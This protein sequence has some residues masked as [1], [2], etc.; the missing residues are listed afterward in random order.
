MKRFEFSSKLQ[1]MSVIVKQ[2]GSSV[3]ARVLVKGSPEKI[4]ELCKPSTL[5]GDFESVLDFY[6]KSGYRVLAAAIRDLPIAA[7]ERE[8]AESN[9]TFVGLLIMQNKLKPATTATI[10]ALKAAH[11]RTI[12]VTGDNI[13]TAI[14]VARQCNLVWAD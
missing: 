13:L 11:I 9:L 14:S 5:P 6:A 7:V 3:N 1:R 10:D 8:E 4:K 12:M 2:I